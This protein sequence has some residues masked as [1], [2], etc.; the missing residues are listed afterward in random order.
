M[1]V[2]SLSDAFSVLPDGT[3]NEGDQSKYNSALTNGQLAAQ[4]PIYLLGNLEAKDGI[5]LAKGSVTDLSGESI[6][7]PRATGLAPGGIFRDGRIIAGGTLQTA[8]GFVTTDTLFDTPIGISDY[9]NL[10]PT[11]VIAAIVSRRMPEPG[12]IFPARPTRSTGWAPTANMCRRRNGV[13]RARWY[14]AMA[15]R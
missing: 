1:A 4:D 6:V 13:T 12:S 14:W 5:V 15:E 2:H 8:S 3:I 10:N 11:T 9:A 7:N